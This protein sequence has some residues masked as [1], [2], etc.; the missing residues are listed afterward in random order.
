MAPGRGG[1]MPTNYRLSE[2]DKKRQ[3]ELNS[4]N[5]PLFWLVY[6]AVIFVVLGYLFINGGG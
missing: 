2:Y 1:V 5:A 6:A 3:E 4:A